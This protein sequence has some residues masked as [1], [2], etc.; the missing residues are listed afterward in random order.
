MY[1]IHKNGI[2]RCSVEFSFWETRKSKL[3]TI[4]KLIFSIENNNLCL[5]GEICGIDFNVEKILQEL[6]TKKILLQKDADEYST[7]HFLT[8]EDSDFET[9]LDQFDSF[10]EGFYT[11]YLFSADVCKLKD[12]D[13]D[14]K[15]MTNYLIKISV[16]SDATYVEFEF[17]NES[18]CKSFIEINKK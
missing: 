18:I 17:M 3:K 12:E 1:R 13:T 14:L 5:G 8:R 10:S 6:K 9:I 2:K 15:R 11:L 7:L 16:H 4:K